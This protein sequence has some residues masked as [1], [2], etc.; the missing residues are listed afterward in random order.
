MSVPRNGRDS[1]VLGEVIG[2]VM[3]P[4]IRFATLK[5]FYGSRELIN[6]CEIRPSL[7]VNPPAIEIQGN[8]PMSVYYYTLVMVDPDA[9][10][11][12]N[13]TEREYLHWLVTNIPATGNINAG[14]EIV[15]YESPR[16]SLGIHRYVFVLF[17]HMEMK[18][19]SHPGW[20][21]NFYTREFAE[22][23]DLR[24]PVAASY[25]TCQRESNYR[26]RRR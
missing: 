20:R 24:M 17:R 5:V 12:G 7:T 25:F 13:P 22:R 9:P 23:Y 21:Q 15:A 2:D 3:D 18:S 6:A 10:S 8:D 14:Q 11:P 16:P 19:I 4:F 1:L 26:G